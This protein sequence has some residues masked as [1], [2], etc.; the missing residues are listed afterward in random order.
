MRK[1]F[2]MTQADLDAIFDAIK[3]VPYIIIGGYAPPRQQARANDAW[4]A[5][6]ARMGFDGMSVRPSA[7]GDRF[8]TA[9]AMTPNVDMGQ[10]PSGSD[11]A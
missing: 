4:Q 11:A 3:P 10:L 1:E 8:F 5:L 6:G 9:E 2:E 7:K